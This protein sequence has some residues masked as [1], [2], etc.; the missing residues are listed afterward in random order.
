MRGFR[1]FPALL[2]VLTSAAAADIAVYRDAPNSYVGANIMTL[3][4]QGTDLD[5]TPGGFLFR[6]GGMV[7]P[8][9][10]AELR[11]GRGFWHETE[12]VPGSRLQVD[13]DHIIGVYGTG[14]LPFDVPL[15]ELPLVDKLF[16][17]ALVGIA[18]VQ[19]RSESDTCAGGCRATRVRHDAATDLS[20]GVGLG[21]ELALPK[22]EL[23][24]FNSPRRIGLSLEYMN[25][26]A[27]YDIDLTGVEAGIMVFF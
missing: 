14:R 23:P 5:Q 19:L 26:G 2:L 9:F 21:M 8:H 11:L 7:D 13:V 15:I 22:I 1:F 6:L 12:R 18:D 20:W 4:V 3:N 10:G 24:V 16:V 17:H 25:Y 27:K